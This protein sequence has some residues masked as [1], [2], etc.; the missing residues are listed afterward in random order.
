MSH[1]LPAWARCLCVLFLLGQLVLPAQASP[2]MLAAAAQSVEAKTE[3]SSFILPPSSFR[4]AAPALA[5]LP[6]VEVET[7]AED[8]A[9]AEAL[10]LHLSVEPTQAEPGEVITYT[11]T[12][13][14]TGDAPLTAIV[15][16]DTLPDGL[17][18]VTKSAVGFTYV[19]R[20]QQLT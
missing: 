12:V 19:P 9:K 1:R 16:T 2:Q 3:A 15:L 6:A 13:A 5:A 10:N 20:D 7:K 17:V 18:Y 14:N 8:Q 4:L 11:A